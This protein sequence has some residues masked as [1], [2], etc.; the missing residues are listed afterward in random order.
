MT[1]PKRSKPAPI[2]AELGRPETPEETAARKA[3]T[4]RTHRANQTLIN[5]IW[6]LVATLAVVLVLVLV[7]VRPSP[8]VLDPVD[9]HAVAEQ[10][11]VN[12]EVPLADPQLPA[13][14]T[15]NSASLTTAADGISTWYIGFITPSDTF[16]AMSQGIEANPTWVSTLLESGIATGS[17]TIEGI[18]WQVYDNREGEDPGN[19]AYAMS[20][21]VGDSSYVIYGTADSNEFRTLATALEAEIQASSS[22]T[23]GT[24]TGETTP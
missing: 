7:V 17:E 14:W 24:T 3:E 12:S 18:D 4:S 5:L 1:D 22:T 10:A 8:E 13:Q 20:T 21:T 2:V 11:Q 23:D 19:L 15:S 16:I 6:S 9:Y